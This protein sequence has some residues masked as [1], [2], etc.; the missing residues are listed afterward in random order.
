MRIDIGQSC[1]VVISQHRR[2]EN[3]EGGK[4]VRVQHQKKKEKEKVQTMVPEKWV[5]WFQLELVPYIKHAQ[6]DTNGL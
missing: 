3:F 1:S 2:H 4:N 5:V 6:L